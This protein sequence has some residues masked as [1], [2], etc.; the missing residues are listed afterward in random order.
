MPIF[1]CLRRF[2]VC[3]LH[4]YGGHPKLHG[5]PVAMAKESMVGGHGATMPMPMPMHTRL[6]LLLL[7][8][9][10]PLKK[11]HKDTKTNVQ[12]SAKSN[13]KPSQGPLLGTRGCPRWDPSCQ[14]E[15]ILPMRLCQCR[16]SVCQ[17]WCLWICL[18]LFPMPTPTLVL[19]LSAG[20]GGGY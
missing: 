8:F 19:R 1:P 11:E 18:C 14:E 20:V 16:F 9:L 13:P 7:L 10:S 3:E 5:M 6:C 12:G 17:R 4:A 15:L 2:R